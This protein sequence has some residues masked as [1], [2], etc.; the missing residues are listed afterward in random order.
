M[1]RLAA[2]GLCALGLALPA[3]A[4]DTFTS[5]VT[6]SDSDSAEA[7]LFVTDVSVLDGETCIGNGCVSDET[8]GSDVTLKLRDATPSLTFIDSSS[9][10]FPDRDWKLVVND[11]DSGG[12]ERFS[13]KDG[14]TGNIPF[15]VTGG[16][17]ESALVLSGSNVGLGTSLPQK[18]L[19]M[20]AT[21]SPTIRLELDASALTPR[22]FDLYLAPGGFVVH[23]ELAGTFPFRVNAE[24]PTY[25]LSVFGDG[26]IGI[27]PS[28]A[29][30]PLH[31]QRD[32]GTARV[33]V[34]NTG[35]D[36]GVAREMF[37]MTNNGGSYFTL[38]NTDSGTTWFFNH[39]NAA[40][41]RFIIA[42]AVADGPEMSLSAD[43]V[44]TVPGGF[45]V[46][47][48]TLNV[49]DYVFAPEYDLT[50]LSEVSAFIAENRHLPDVPSAAQ[51]ARDGLDMTDMQM[52]HLK[53]IEELTLYTLAQE[54]RL[55]AQAREIAD[56][57]KLVETLLE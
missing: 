26:E 31:V 18:A 35:G 49:P 5:G 32:D 57:R 17:Q 36:P 15:T 12:L 8:F 19:H 37:N 6:I 4:Q 2:C 11:P 3:A 50:P 1:T 22:I 51:I 25:A 13:I 34:E 52:R 33:L 39:E 45:V 44:L 43:G 38:D 27:G 9:P 10:P 21:N 20:V 46:G 14:E 23:D 29:A 30:A 40:P 48:T 56:L 7:D 16:A 41:N 55:E 53:K 24:A 28:A 54:A 42:D 47:S